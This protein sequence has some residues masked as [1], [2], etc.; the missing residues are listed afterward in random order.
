MKGCSSTVLSL[1]PFTL[2]YK[3]QNYR[4]SDWTDR[5]TRAGP[6][7]RTGP[8]AHLDR[9]SDVKWLPLGITDAELR[10]S[11]IER[12]QWYLARKVNNFSNWPQ[13]SPGKD[14]CSEAEA[15][16]PR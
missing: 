6:G 13:F 11:L 10:F 5:S 8:R 3:A 2:P 15:L 7:D 9:I 14:V 4:I 16:F 1:G 12:F